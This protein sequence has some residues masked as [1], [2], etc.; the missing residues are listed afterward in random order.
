MKVTKTKG[1]IY[2]RKKSA[3]LSKVDA[4]VKINVGILILGLRS[5]L[6]NF[7]IFELTDGWQHW[8]VCLSISVS[9]FL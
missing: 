4:E 9:A 7:F 2:C 6:V 3:L 8:L 1:E 5:S